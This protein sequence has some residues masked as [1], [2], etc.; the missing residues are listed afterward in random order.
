MLCRD[1]TWST[2]VGFFSLTFFSCNNDCDWFFMML[3]QRHYKSY[4]PTG[5]SQV[6]RIKKACFILN[7]NIYL[8][9]QRRLGFDSS[10][11]QMLC[12][13]Y[14][15]IVR[16]CDELNLLII[17]LPEWTCNWQNIKQSQ[18]K[19]KTKNKRTNKQRQKNPNTFDC[20]KHRHVCFLHI[21]ITMIHK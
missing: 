19:T 16:S 4:I 17:T 15:R 3:D 9:Q 21:N 20:G 14:T 10:M 7:L 2:Y 13:V 1:S 18:K 8:Q 5:S 6:F 12:T 11:M